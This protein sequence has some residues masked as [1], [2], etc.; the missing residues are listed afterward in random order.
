VPRAAFVT[1][2]G[3]LPAERVP[4]ESTVRMARYPSGQRGQTVN[5]LANAFGGSNPPLATIV[6]PSP[7]GA[8]VLRTT[9]VERWGGLPADHGRGRIPGDRHD[10]G[11]G[12]EAGMTP[13]P[14]AAGI[15][16]IA[17]W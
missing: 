13:R 1:S 14:Q 6:E 4:L 9:C 2:V 5:L 3:R 11:V 8:Q 15:A 10:S 16:G 7:V 17:Q 12:R